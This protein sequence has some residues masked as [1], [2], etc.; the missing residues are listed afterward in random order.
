MN[1]IGHHFQKVSENEGSC[2]TAVCNG[3]TIL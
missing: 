2:F 1:R 3:L